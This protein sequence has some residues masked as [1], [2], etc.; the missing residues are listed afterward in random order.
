MRCW[1]DVGA[2]T[3]IALF[4]GAGGGVWASRILGHQVVCYVE[5][6]PFRHAV[7]RARIRDGWFDDAPI[8]NDVTTFDGKP[9]CGLVD[10]VTGG[11]PCQPF[12]LAGKRREGADKRNMWPDTARVIGEVRPAVALL[13]NVPG[14]ASGY[15][16][17]VI[18]DLATLGYDAIWG[19]LP[20]AAVGAPHLRRRLWIVAVDT[21]GHRGR[22]QIERLAHLPEQ[23]GPRWDV[24]LRCRGAESSPTH[25][26][27]DAAGSRWHPQPSAIRSRKPEPHCTG[28]MG[29]A[30]RRRCETLRPPEHLGWREAEPPLCRVADG[31]ANRRH[32]LAALGD[33]Q[34]PLCAATA[35][36]RLARRYVEATS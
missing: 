12:S 5:F 1:S 4:A 10:I 8:W 22:R 19:V 24:A 36:V 31:L 33:G 26:V 15:L 16:T 32:R 6:N 27:G 3:E 34:V 20:A 29:H 25:D 2:P 17:T 11:F 30:Q 13:E 21:N 18:G 23:Q 7:L 35:Y 9:W 14:L 28:G